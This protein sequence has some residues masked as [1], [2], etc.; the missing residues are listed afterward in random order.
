MIAHLRKENTACSSIDLSLICGRQTTPTIFYE[1]L[2]HSLIKNLEIPPDC[3]E[4]KHWKDKQQWLYLDEQFIEF[5]ETVVLR[6]IQTPV[7]IFLDEL[8]SL[9]TLP[10]SCDQFLQILRGFYDRRSFSHGNGLERL[11]FVLLGVTS[12]S[13]LISSR[14][15][16]PF[17][18][19]HFIE[20]KDFQLEECQPL[21][22][23]L[24]GVVDDSYTVIKEILSWTG[25][26]PLLTQ[27]LCWLVTQNA[28]IIAGEEAFKIKQIVQQRILNNWEL[29]ESPEHLKTIRDRLFWEQISLVREVPHPSPSWEGSLR[30]AW[31]QLR[32]N[33][34]QSPPSTKQLLKL[35][36][37]LLKKE[38]IPYSARHHGQRYLLMS[39]LARV[40][41][42]QLVIKNAIYRAVFSE[43]WVENSL[44]IIHPQTQL[45]KSSIPA[46]AG[47]IS[48]CILGLR[49]LSLLQ[50]MELATYDHL[51]RQMPKESKDER[52]VIVGANEDDIARY[53]GISDQILT[54]VIQKLTAAGAVGIGIDIARNVPQPPGEQALAREFLHNEK[55]IGVCSLETNPHQQIPPPP[56]L[57]PHRTAHISIENDSAYGYQD[58]TVR[59]YELSSQTSQPTPCL[60]HH[61]LGL[62]L[63]AFYLQENKVSVKIQNQQWVFGSVT[64]HRLQPHTGGYHNL[65]ARGNQLL[66]RYRHTPDPNQ[67]V[68][69]ISFQE[70]LGKNFD[71]DGIKDKVVLIGKTGISAS[72][73]HQ[74][75]YGQMRGIHIH[76]HFVSQILSAV[77]DDRALICGLPWGVDSLLIVLCGLCG[78]AIALPATALINR[79]IILSSSGIA[80][81]SISWY[82]FFLGIWLPLLPMLL[83]LTGSSLLIWGY[84]KRH[85]GYNR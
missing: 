32:E 68:S 19:G 84:Q 81:Y 58:Y 64:A 1:S 66:L 42:G 47:I 5:I 28:P 74:T 51:L 22:L 26:Q 11:S 48:L 18:I 4:Y 31:R 14:H 76:A 83:T 67:P 7:V 53:Q 55:V 2:F 13:D 75:P 77:E 56:T 44:A 33:K 62:M 8:D 3:P 45:P 30:H 16:A 6:C 43:K 39:G 72:D 35:Y 73:L 52:I 38:N 78:S 41:K 85:Q 49:C 20:L 46:V 21:E 23:G 82:F 60:A 29:D 17:N 37:R 25:G 59:R 54:E 40:E 61:T 79:I 63:S 71:P 65:D 12:P 50:G 34:K 9:L 70:V 24:K 57:P 10:F 15:C 27:K 69:E 80:L 36:Q